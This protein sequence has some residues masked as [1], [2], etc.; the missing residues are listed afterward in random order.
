MR[1]GEAETVDEA[2]KQEAAAE[3]PIAGTRKSAHTAAYH[4]DRVHMGSRCASLPMADPCMQPTGCGWQSAWT[5]P[6]GG[7]GFWMGIWADVT[8]SVGAALGRWA[9]V[10]LVRDTELS[11]TRQARLHTP[12]K[13]VHGTGHQ[14]GHERVLR[15]DVVIIHNTVDVLLLSCSQEVDLALR[16]D[17]EKAGFPAA[18]KAVQQAQ[19]IQRGGAILDWIKFM[20]QECNNPATL[21]HKSAGVTVDWGLHD[22]Q[23]AYAVM[24]SAELGENG[25]LPPSTLTLRAATYEAHREKLI[26]TLNTQ[27]RRH[28]ARKRMSTT[29]TGQVAQH[30]MLPSLRLTSLPQADDAV[31]RAA[32][33]FEGTC[34]SAASDISMRFFSMLPGIR[35]LNAVRHALK[36]GEDV[37]ATQDA[38]SPCPFRGGTDYLYTKGSISAQGTKAWHD[39]SNGPACLT[40]WQNF[41]AVTGETL[42]LAV[43]IHGCKVVLEGDVGKSVLFMAWLPHRTQLRAADGTVHER[44]DAVRLHHTA[45]VRSGTEY[46]AITLGEYKRRGLALRG[47]VTP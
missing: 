9:Q 41:G 28:F 18:A 35:A 19:G 21:G 43:G 47:Y 23:T 45:Y 30:V 10:T 20:N 37:W 26:S 32:T 13:K 36:W 33:A 1:E 4:R 39:D 16:L 38:D 22:A 17:L 31:A 12:V 29:G 34:R 5:M 6:E 25:S 15:G 42:E 44:K 24:L 11:G 8:R 46:A 27:G 14:T 40:C 2:A 7:H 3:I